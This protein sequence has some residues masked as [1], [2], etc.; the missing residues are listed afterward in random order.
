[1]VESFDLLAGLLKNWRF[2]FQMGPPKG[3]VSMA[4]GTEE[5][6]QERAL[7]YDRVYQK[8]ERQAD[9]QLVRKWLAPFFGGLRVLEIATGTGYWTD[10]IAE[11]ALGIVATDINVATLRVAENRRTWPDNVAFVEADAFSLDT[12][13]G[14]FDAAFVGFFWSHIPLAVLG[15]FLEGLFRRVEPGAPA[16][17]LDNRYVEGSNHPLSGGD[18]DG[19]T[20]QMRSLE[21]GR[22]YEVL[23][24]FPTPEFL[25]TKLEPLAIDVTRLEWEFYWAVT[26]MAK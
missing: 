15:E 17:F 9:L 19:N 21:D 26:G 5:Y 3:G 12:V 23:K 14:E 6:Y 25:R 11:G 16:V 8:P 7:E 20:Y 24:N 1:V 18:G 10:V 4:T 13:I 2:G 22:T